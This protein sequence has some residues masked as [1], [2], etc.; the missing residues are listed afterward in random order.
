MNPSS[1][2]MSPYAQKLVNLRLPRYQE[3]PRID[4]Y[5]DQLIG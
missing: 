1:I 3:I 5:L 2:S 4:L